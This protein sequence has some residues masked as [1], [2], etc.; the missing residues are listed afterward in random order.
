MTLEEQARQIFSA[1]PLVARVNHQ[2]RSAVIAVLRLAAMSFPDD[3]TLDD[4]DLD[5]VRAIRPSLW[6]YIEADLGDA[7]QTSGLPNNLIEDWERALKAV[8]RMI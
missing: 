8:R 3:G 6:P 1:L 5:E 4:G 7:I 2:M